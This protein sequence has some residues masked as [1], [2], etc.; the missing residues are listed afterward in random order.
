MPS[1]EREGKKKRTILC[2][3]AQAG[4]YTANDTKD[5]HAELTQDG[6]AQHGVHVR[7]Q[8]QVHPELSAKGEREINSLEFPESRREEINQHRDT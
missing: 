2:I 4:G 5:R 7:V 3:C 6:T 1:E 8:V